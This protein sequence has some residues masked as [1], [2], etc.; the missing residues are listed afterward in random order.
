M[1]V[2]DVP[3]QELI[4]NIAKSLQDDY[5]ISQPDFLS[6]VKTG[7]HRERMPQ[8]K[9]WFYVRMGSILYRLFKDGPN[10]VGSFRAYYG[11]RKNRGVKPHRF[12]KAS[13]KVIRIAFQ[14]LEKAELVVK[15]KKGRTISKQGHSLLVKKSKE[16]Q[17]ESL[18]EQ[19]PQFQEQISKPEQKKPVQPL[20]QKKP[21]EKIEQKP[22][23]VKPKEEQNQNEK[24]KTKE[25]ENKPEEKVVEKKE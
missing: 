15:L 16:L 14:E 1:G 11:G 6:Y 8:R 3:A 23:I 24:Q 19:A 25:P 22:E 2:F 13:G 17:K 10:G 7:S 9:D 21:V 4:D 5:K 20:S 18:P 12:R